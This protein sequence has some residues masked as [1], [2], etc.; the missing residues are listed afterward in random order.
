M[1]VHLTSNQEQNRFD[2]DCLHNFNNMEKLKRIE[3]NKKKIGSRNDRRL[4]KYSTKFLDMF[5][6]YFEINRKGIITFCGDRT[7]IYFNP[8]GRDAKFTFREYDNGRFKNKKIYCKH[9][10]ILKSVLI[11]KKGWGLH[12]KMWSEGI[13]ECNF[14][15][16]EIL[17][18]FKDKNIK[19]PESL[20]IEFENSIFKHKQE[21]WKR[22]IY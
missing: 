15:L 13:S 21:K 4:E 10:N 12:V 5:K 16:D 17:K 11:G 1:V 22:E 6:F 14:T 19:I 18:Q 3:E 2:P 9:N 8:N 20:L 7:D